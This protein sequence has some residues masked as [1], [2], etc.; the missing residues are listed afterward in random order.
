MAS[1][2]FLGEVRCDLSGDYTLALLS[3]FTLSMAGTLSILDL[4]STAHH[5]IPQW[6]EALP[7]EVR[8]STS[9]RPAA[10]PSHRRL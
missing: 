6:E 10:A 1:G 9:V 5:Q 4:P 8:S 3:S 7:P 2:A